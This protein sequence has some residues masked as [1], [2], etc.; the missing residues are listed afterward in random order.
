[1][2]N[3]SI[4]WLLITKIKMKMMI[5]NKM[6][7]RIPTKITSKIMQTSK[8]VDFV[9]I[10]VKTLRSPLADTFSVGSVQSKHSP[11]KLNVLCAGRRSSLSS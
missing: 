5:I 1:M 8:I 11:S 7:L 6:E 9:L 2:K 3:P 4:L 10:P